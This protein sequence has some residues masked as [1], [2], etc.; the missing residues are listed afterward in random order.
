MSEDSSRD[1][2]IARLESVWKYKFSC[3]TRN[4][5][6]KDWS[7]ILNLKPESHPALSPGSTTRAA[8]FL[9][10]FCTRLSLKLSRTAYFSTTGSSLS[11][12]ALTEAWWSHRSDSRCRVFCSYSRVDERGGRRGEEGRFTYSSAV[13]REDGI[14]RLCCNAKGDF[15]S[16]LVCF[17][18]LKH[19][20]GAVIPCQSYAFMESLQFPL[21]QIPP[22]LPPPPPTPSPLPPPTTLQ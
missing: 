19:V 3:I 8:T 5:A 1:A 12:L 17:R 2:L 11:G 15:G 6:S 9:S 10:R 16:R 13:I 21:K 18:V 4:R 20:I 14:S 22:S 7:V